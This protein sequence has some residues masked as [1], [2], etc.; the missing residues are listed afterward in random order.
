[1][2]VAGAAQPASASAHSAAVTS[3]F[4]EVPL[5]ADPQVAAGSGAST[6]KGSA[7]LVFL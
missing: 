7:F 5:L 2:R 1:M 6:V 4:M 3:S